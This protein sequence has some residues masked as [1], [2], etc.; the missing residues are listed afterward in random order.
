MVEFDPSAAIKRKIEANEP[1]D[2]TVLTTD[3]IDSLA[4]EG[5]LAAQGRAQIG[6]IGVGVGVITG[7]AKPDVRTPDA[8]K[9]TLLNAKGMTW[10]LEGASRPAI[11]K[12]VQEFGIADRIKTKVRLTKNVDES[13]DLVRSGQADL[14]ITLIS[15]ILPAKSVDFVGPLPPK[16]QDYVKFATGISAASKNMDAA[17]AAVKF[18][19]GPAVA[20]AF[21]SKGVEP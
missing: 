4:K 8:I 19:T 14:V 13:M 16:F 10:G 20:P 5:K 3:V 15:E 12:M 6:R 21:K 11:D 17:Q 18:I 2:V 9:Q 1:F 7:A